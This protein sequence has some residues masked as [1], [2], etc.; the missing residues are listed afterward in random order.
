MLYPAPVNTRLASPGV[1]R[2]QGGM[3][4]TRCEHDA[5]G[6]QLRRKTRVCGSGHRSDSSATRI[7]SSDRKTQELEDVLKLE[8]CS[9][10]HDGEA[11]RQ[12]MMEDPVQ[13]WSWSPSTCHSAT[14]L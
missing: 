6:R 14:L 4:R 1:C 7:L 12:W 10:H 8:S 13:S 9:H 2:G 3:T 5:F 11:P